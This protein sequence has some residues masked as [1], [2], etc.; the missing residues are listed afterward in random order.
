[1][2][3]INRTVL[4]NGIQLICNILRCRI[5]AALTYFRAKGKAK[6]IDKLLELK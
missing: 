1:M 5:T 2:S 6:I 3:S 4:Q